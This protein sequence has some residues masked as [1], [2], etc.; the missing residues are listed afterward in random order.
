MTRLFHDL[1]E[2][3]SQMAV[4]E[5]EAEPGGRGASVLRTLRRIADIRSEVDQKRDRQYLDVLLLDQQ[6]GEG[7]VEPT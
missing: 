7:A 2:L 4:I 1:D 5:V 6:E 3:L